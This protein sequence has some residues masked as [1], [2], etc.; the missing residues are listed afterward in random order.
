MGVYIQCMKMP[1]SCDNC[2]FRAQSIVADGLCYLTGRYL[3]CECPLVEVPDGHGR[4]IDADALV[5][6]GIGKWTT[7]DLERI[8]KASTVIQADH[9]SNA[10]NKE[11]TV[12]IEEPQKSRKEYCQGFCSRCG[13][14]VI[15][16]K[17]N[18][19]WWPGGTADDHLC[20]R[21]D[22]CGGLAEV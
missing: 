15:A 21:C 12:E 17:V 4:L 16:E 11:E 13:R 20:I 10:G 14:P 19:F 1:K 3:P 2:L 8:G 5:T 22:V 7:Y 6:D 18:A 9:S